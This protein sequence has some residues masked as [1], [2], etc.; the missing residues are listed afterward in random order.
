M[1]ISEDANEYLKTFMLRTMSLLLFFVHKTSLTPT[2]FIKLPYQ[3]KFVDT[4]GVIR[5]R[6]FKKDRQLNGQKI[7]KG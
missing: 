5:I 2:I 7:P 4:K 6:K 3:E 1:I